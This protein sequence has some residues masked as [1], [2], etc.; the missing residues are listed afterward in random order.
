MEPEVR[1]RFE[2]IEATLALS[3]ETHRVAMERL[4]KRMA[5]ADKRM[6]R[7]DA[8]LAGPR[9]LVVSGMQVVNHLAKENREARADTKALKAEMKEF[10]DEVRSYIKAQGNGHKRSGGNGRH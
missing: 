6:D 10:K 1:E 4:D 5:A 3:A 2:R 9:K 8:S 7:F